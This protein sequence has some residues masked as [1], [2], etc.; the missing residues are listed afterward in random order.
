MGYRKAGAQSIDLRRTGKF[1]LATAREVSMR[2]ETMLEKNVR[3]LFSVLLVLLIS[4]F[5]MACKRDEAASSEG[6]KASPKT[7]KTE[8]PA[9]PP[10][11]AYS[12]VGDPNPWFTTFAAELEKEGK[13]RGYKLIVAHAQAKIEKQLADVEDLVAQK[14]EVLI[15][16]PI[17]VKGSA[18]CLGVAK[19]AGVPVIVVNRDIA[20]TPGKDYVTRLHSDFEW[21]GA[22]QAEVIKK[23][24]GDKPAKVVELHGTPGGGNTIGLQKGFREK[25]KEL[26][27][28]EIVASQLG[29]YTRATALKS[30]ENVIQSMGGKFNAV[31]GHSDEEAI[32]AI[33]ALKKA[34][35]KVGDGKDGSVV[36]VGNG[37]VKDAIKAI[38]A[39]ELYASVTVSPYYANQVFDAYE[40]FK[41]K[42]KLPEYIRVDDF[43][44]DASN[45]A[46]HES[47]GF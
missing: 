6:D 47:F 30:M 22:K 45:V 26:G 21:V 28:M 24:L 17:D 11:L 46:K 38:Q 12:S 1:P 42:K 36:V 43:A 41:A 40:G 10:L 29:D 31:F 5:G 19:A 20:G 33:Q 4:G 15:L 8:K 23:A 32:A 14:P 3:T 34:G 13:K 9:G 16:G 25:M 44:I 27:G 7:E 2:R 39:G 35:R 37:G 18:A